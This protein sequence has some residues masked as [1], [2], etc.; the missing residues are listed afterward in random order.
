M[1]QSL[2]KCFGF[3]VGKKFDKA[4]TLYNRHL[5]QD[6]IEIFED[7]LLEKTSARSLYHNLAS[8]YCGY[9]Y[10][11][12]GLGQFGMGNYRDA[13]FNFRKA[14]GLAADQLDLHQF[15]GTCLNNLGEHEEA[16]KVFR[17]LLELH[18]SRISVKIKLAI[19]LSNL[20]MWE[21]SVKVYREILAEHPNYADIWMRLGLAYLGEGKASEAKEAFSEAL[22]LN[23]RYFEAKNKLGITLAYLGEFEEALRVMGEIIASGRRYADVYYHMAL[24]EIAR[25]RHQEAMGCLGEAL[26]VNPDY[27]EAKIKLGL[28]LC[29]AGD[30]PLGLQ[31]L[32][33]AALRAP[34]DQ[35]LKPLVGAIEEVS[36]SSPSAREEVQ[37]VINQ[38]LG[39]D[40][41][42]AETLQEFHKQIE[43]TPSFS[44]IVSVVLPLM[45]ED[46]SACEMLLPQLQE[47]LTQHP[48][49]PDLHNS[50][51][52][53][54]VK[55]QRLEEA[56][57][58][59]R[60]ATSLNPEYV[61]AHMNL[62]QTLKALGKAH[63]A[64]EEAAFLE[65]K[66]LPYPD[67]YA[68]IAEI[69]LDLALYEKAISYADRALE[70]KGGYAKAYYLRAAVR[71][72]Q[73]QFLE[74]RADLTMCLK[75]NPST[76][77]LKLA[78]EAMLRLMSK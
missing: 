67:L 33:E 10:R 77:L 17:F 48:T 36:T 53:V 29:R 31:Q 20:E 49:Y 41:S 69:Y 43:I 11:N 14:S 34:R 56:E 5:Y 27:K 75:L 24:I 73:H 28:L 22:K 39:E 18:P 16:V 54:Y 78:E 3:Q 76:R 60:M 38:F 30:L 65:G 4:M 21:E 7:I 47:Y 70:I 64:L 74:A 51:G 58:A 66:E 32:K 46:R 44:E 40:K 19:A 72:R 26:A 9:A 8:V 59:F 71:E 35:S 6:A 52:N 23:P 45:E 63:D 13:L 25:D 50:L 12:L 57:Q 61:K 15:I 55:L 62:F 2:R 68:D 1:W 42:L 37:A